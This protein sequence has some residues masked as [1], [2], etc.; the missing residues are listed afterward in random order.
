MSFSLFSLSSFIFFPPGMA[1][2]A[3]GSEDASEDLCLTHDWGSG[4]IRCLSRMTQQ[5][6]GPPNSK[7][8][9]V[10]MGANG[11]S[12]PHSCSPRIGG[13]AQAQQTFIGRYLICGLIKS[14]VIGC[15]VNTKSALIDDSVFSVSV[16][17]NISVTL[18]VSGKTWFSH[19]PLKWSVKIVLL[20]P[21][22]HRA[23]M[24]QTHNRGSIMAELTL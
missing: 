19:S 2:W 21:L 10:R 7:W 15:T 16:W 1:G 24:L 3:R 18:T 14:V 23:P 17:W 22:W 9:E 12:Y 6:G 20:N 8:R 13:N 11:S 4:G 5:E